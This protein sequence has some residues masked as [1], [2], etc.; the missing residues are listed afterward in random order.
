MGKKRESYR[1]R[2]R[3]AE[4]PVNLPTSTNNECQTGLSSDVEALGLASDASQSNLVV[5]SALVFSDIL[6][7]TLEYLGSLL[8]LLLLVQDESAS[9]GSSSL[10]ILLALLQQSLWYFWKTSSCWL[11]SSCFL[12]ETRERGQLASIGEGH[13]RALRIRNEA[14]IDEY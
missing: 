9:S 8:L 11:L 14:E 12:S 13:F 10:S 3:S 1:F 2:Y 5:L 7:S 4:I 6:L